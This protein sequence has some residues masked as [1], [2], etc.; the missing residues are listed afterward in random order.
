MKNKLRKQMRQS[1]LDMDPMSRY[2][3]SLAACKHLTHLKEFVAAD[4]VMIFLS[5]DDEVDTGAAAL[6]AWQMG[7]TVCA[8]KVSWEHHRLTPMEIHSL[9]TGITTGRHGVSEPEDGQPVPLEMIDLVVVPG[10]L[11]DRTGQRLGRGGGF[12]D[13]FC[14][15]AEV[16]ALTCG[17]A[18]ADQ[19]VDHL[20]TESHDHPVDKLVTDEE[21]LDF[22]R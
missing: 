11:F 8:P 2:A 19:L 13:R 12:Y 20:D 17:L 16:R 15:H 22:R 3:R 10:L 5:L 14:A 9:D 18:F 6:A 1:L 7:K 4:V 21:V